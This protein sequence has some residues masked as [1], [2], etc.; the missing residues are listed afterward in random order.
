MQMHYTRV[1][2]PTNI[3]C[4][5]LLQLRRTLKPVSL[6]NYELS[7]R[8]THYPTHIQAQVDHLIKP[9]NLISRNPKAVRHT[10]GFHNIGCNTG[11][12]A[13]TS[14]CS[15]YIDFTERLQTELIKT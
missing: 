8:E 13:E 14:M 3:D 6:G 7:V 2:K 15:G 10:K 5:A 11:K 4:K 12:H 1:A 9:R